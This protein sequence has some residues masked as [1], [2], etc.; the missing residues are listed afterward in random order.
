MAEQEKQSIQAMADAIADLPEE[1]SN[2]SLALR[3][4]LRLWPSRP[5]PKRRNPPAHNSKRR[6]KKWLVLT[7]VIT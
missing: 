4:V 7:P 2:F 3:K 5:A 1:K 6:Y